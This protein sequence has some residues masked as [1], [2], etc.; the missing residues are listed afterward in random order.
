MK[1]NVPYC[2]WCGNTDLDADSYCKFCDVFA[3]LIW[4]VFDAD[5]SAGGKDGNRSQQTRESTNDI[6]F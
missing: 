3:N 2:I 4:E 6:D 1:E 5:A